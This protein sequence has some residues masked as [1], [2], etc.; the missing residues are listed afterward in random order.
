MVSEL[1]AKPNQK[2][3]NKKRERENSKPEDGISALKGKK[4]KA[5]YGEIL[6]SSEVSGLNVRKVC[7]GSRICYSETEQAVTLFTRYASPQTKHKRE[8]CYKHC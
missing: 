1:I 5:I 6:H 7:I 4:K 2:E 3:K 8:L